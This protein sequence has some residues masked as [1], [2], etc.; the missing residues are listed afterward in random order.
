MYHPPTNCFL[1]PPIS[2]HR[3]IAVRNII[4]AGYYV[5]NYTDFELILEIVCAMA[6]DHGKWIKQWLLANSSC[7]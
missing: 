3:D 2:H 7:V 5:T 6:S 1:S 4:D